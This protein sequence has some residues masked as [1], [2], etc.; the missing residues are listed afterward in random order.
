[1]R[2]QVGGGLGIGSLHAQYRFNG[3]IDDVRLFARALSTDEI[4]A[5]YRRGLRAA[6]TEAGVVVK[7]ERIGEEKKVFRK[8]AREIAMSRDGFVWIDAEDFR[9][10]GGW[11]LD[12]QFVY[13]VGSAYLLATGVGTPVA[14]ATT[15]FELPRA[16]SYRVWVRARNWIKEHAPGTFQ[17]LVN[18]KAL[19]ETF[20]DADS[21]EW[22]WEDGGH[23]DPFLGRESL[24]GPARPYRLL[25]ALRRHRLRPRSGLS[26]LRR[27]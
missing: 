4:A 14:D 13:L 15:E 27:P 18:G 12:T 21:G 19:G 23:R 2:I 16:G 10:Y 22:T 1:M 6:A 8:P 25:R 7:T 17:L 11:T 26:P 24:P 5:S 20:G 9:D 3:V